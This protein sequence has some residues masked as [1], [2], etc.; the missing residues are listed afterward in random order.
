MKLLRAA[1]LTVADLDAA[2]ALYRDYLDYTT[3][4]RGTLGA[5]LAEA[6]NAP[7]SAGARSLV[8]APASGA[9]I[10]LRLVEQKPVPEY[11]PL[12]TYG[13]NSIEICVQDVLAAHER[14]KASPFE[15]IGPPREIE[16]LPAIYPMQMKGPDGEIVYLTQ[17]R[18][19]LPAYDLPRATAPIDRL[20]ILV[21]GCSDMHA[22][23]KWFDDTLGFETGR[24]M[25][26]EYHMLADAFGTPKTE[27]HT[28]STGIHGRD[29]F[30][31]L[32]QYP[33][34]ATERPRHEGMLVPGCCV[35]SFLHPDFDAIKGEWVSPPTVREGAPYNGKRSGTLRG[36]DGLLVEV[37]EL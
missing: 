2:E 27:L 22:S 9:E 37:I 16:G 17:I 3:V 7:K 31:E 15:V 33:P 21:I 14:I 20:F 18:D 29:V 30:L 23:L 32:D 24:V 35:G 6:F 11:K 10:Y 34:A 1:T 12:T 28:I 19:D 13:W 25:E 4:S 5:D 36:P 26:I 8:M